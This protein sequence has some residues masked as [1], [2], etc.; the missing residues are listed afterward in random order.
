VET[1]PPH[2]PAPWACRNGSGPVIGFVG[3]IEPR[4]GPLD[5]V[6]AAPAIRHAE[7]HARIVVVGDDPY[8]AD[9]AYTSTVTGSP[10]IEHHPWSGNAPGLMR[11][12]DVLVLPSYQEPFGTVLAEAMAVGTPVVATNVDGLPEVVQDG[13]TGRL[14]APGAPAELARAVLE[15]VARKAEMGAAAKASAARFNAD[16]YADRIERLIAP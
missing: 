10:E 12:L 3:R 8:D 15:V 1:D 6:R 11:H 7:P 4:K 16:G 9:R 2:A 14:V 13:V 5:L